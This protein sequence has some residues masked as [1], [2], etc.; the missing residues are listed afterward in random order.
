M[1]LYFAKPLSDMTAFEALRDNESRTPE[2]ETEFNS[3][4]ATLEANEAR[5]ATDIANLRSLTPD[6]TYHVVTDEAGCVAV[7]AMIDGGES[8]EWTTIVN[9]LGGDTL[10]SYFNAL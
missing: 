9:E 4:L 6:T 3:L 1:R 5:I 7:K 2:Q 8:V 10:Y